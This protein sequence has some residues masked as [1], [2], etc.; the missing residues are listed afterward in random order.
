MLETSAF[1][2]AYRHVLD[3]LISF[4]RQNELDFPF[5]ENLIECK[6]TQ[7]GPAKYLASATLDFGYYIYIYKSFIFCGKIFA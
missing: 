7:I 6:N 1:F 5:R 4:E 2:E 3:A